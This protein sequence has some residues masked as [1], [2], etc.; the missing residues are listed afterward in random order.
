MPWPRIHQ[1]EMVR[2]A[3][4][5][6]NNA[7]R[8]PYMYH[9]LVAQTNIFQVSGRFTYPDDFEWEPK[10]RINEAPLYKK[11]DDQGRLYQNSKFHDL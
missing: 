10:V 11:N 2:K 3:D 9:V 4:Q 1:K 7:T 8:Q 6:I 5:G